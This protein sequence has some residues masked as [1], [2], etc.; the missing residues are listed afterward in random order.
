[1]PGHATTRKQVKVGNGQVC[2]YFSWQALTHRVGI[3]LTDGQLSPNLQDTR[4][5]IKSF[6]T[7][8][9]VLSFCFL[10]TP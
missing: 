10:M 2:T 1:M 7:E 8:I 6:C 4:P 9:A 5:L 3:H